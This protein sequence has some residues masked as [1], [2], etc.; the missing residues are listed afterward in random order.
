M[1]R[2]EKICQNPECEELIDSFQNPKK[3]F[4]IISCKNR[5]HYL[6]DK[7]E[8]YEFEQYEKELKTNYDIIIHFLNK[9][10]FKI[11]DD[12]AKSLGFKTNV[13]MSLERLVKDEKQYKSFRQIKDVFFRYNILEEV[14]EFCDWERLNKVYKP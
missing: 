11:K 12:V 7:E 4:C 3:L 8:N 9:S 10:V 5:F 6:V 1:A 2:K 13:F 14:I